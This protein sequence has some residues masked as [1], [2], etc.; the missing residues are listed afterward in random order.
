MR[1][2]RFLA[3]MLASLFVVSC[4]GVA[5]AATLTG[6]PV[7]Q[8]TPIPIQAKAAILV[9]P[10]SGQIIFEMNA[11]ERLPIASVTKV[12]GV[13][14]ACEAL[15]QGRVRTDEMVTVSKQAEGMGGSQVL[16]DVGEVQPFT[17]L[18]KSMIVGSAND[19]TVAVGEHLFGSEELFVQRMNQRAQ[20]LGMENTKF[21]NST[22][23]PTKAEHYCSAR[24]VARMSME[25]VKHKIYFD[26]STIW[27]DE[28]NHGDGRTTQLTNTN[29]LVRTYEG[30]DGVKTGST[31]EAGYCMAASAKRGD[32]RLIAV[33]LGATT[34]KERFAIAGKIMDYG[35]ANY[36]N[37]V[38]AE[39]GAKVRGEM[40][41]TGGKKDGV[42]LILGDDLQMLVQKGDEQE[43][44]LVPQLPQSLHAPILE[45]QKVGSVDVIRGERK[46]GEIKVIAAESIERQDYGTGWQRIFGRWFY[47]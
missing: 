31:S 40:K 10:N 46:V 8:D 9:E 47:Q 32:M 45:G 24:D 26:Y 11:D 33:V 28:V 7:E 36:R 43:I 35:F 15:E 18:L 39:R 41:V 3:L 16:L 30:A 12:M 25:L 1:I 38:V 37:F 14:L 2:R 27:M 4:A 19:A 42:Q 6:A 20:E 29:R 44:D 21:G 5:Q 22:G 23:L 34:G 13:L 17:V